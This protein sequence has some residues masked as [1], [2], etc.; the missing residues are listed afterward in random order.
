[1]LGGQPIPFASVETADIPVRGANAIAINANASRLYVLGASS[2]VV[3]DTSSHSVFANVSLPGTNLGGIINAGLAIDYNTGMV[4][5]SVEGK[6]VEVNGST[7]SVTGQLPF[8][9]GTLAFD[10]ATHTLWGTQIWELSPAM[11]SNGSLV[12][13]DVRTGSV[14]AN[15]SVGFAPYDIAVDPHNGMVY[16]AGC[17]GSFVCGAEAAV[18]NGTSGTLVNTVGLPSAYY[19]TMTLSPTSDVLYVSG[20]R[21][22]AALNG[23]NGN[24]IFQA[25][26]QTCGPFVGMGVNPSSNQVL[27][28]PQNY[29]YLLAYDGTTGAL[30]NMY[31]F[32]GPVG[33]VAFSLSTNEIYVTG[34]AG[35]LALRPSASTGN[36]NSTLI[37]SY[38]NCLPV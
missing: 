15:V 5:A 8:S 13:V 30:V 12:A 21:L 6:V 27:M 18:V 29:D 17:S 32:P 1:M 31:S 36:V 11:H 4:Y 16:S 33:A 38:Q 37:G 24:Q 14:I 35:L 28:V 7:N 2:L 10:S 22:L 25:D 19:T 3:V 26:P 20:E 9:L 23:T 34:S